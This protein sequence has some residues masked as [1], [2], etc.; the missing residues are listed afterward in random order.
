M[1][2]GSCSSDMT[3][4][5]L[6][7]FIAIAAPAVSPAPA[8]RSRPA[9]PR[10]D[11]SDF[12]PR[13]NGPAGS[14]SIR[15]RSRSRQPTSMGPLL[16]RQF[17]DQPGLA[18]PADDPDFLVKLP[19]CIG[20]TQRGAPPVCGMGVADD[21]AAIDQARQQARNLRLVDGAAA[22][23]VAQR[24]RAEFAQHR[25]GSPLGEAEPV[26]RLQFV[27][28]LAAQQRRQLVQA[29]GVELADENRPAA[30][31]PGFA[32]NGARLPGCG[33]FPFVLRRLGARFCPIR[34]VTAPAVRF[35]LDTNS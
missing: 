28:H 27:V 12:F 23:N 29:I 20:Q 25:N 16:A 26:P 19:A 8:G 17:F 4:T 33:G 15:A 6:C 11:H 32:H 22:R 9:S 14:V 34:H 31:R 13:A 21:V 5:R 35:Q 2:R 10:L 24:Q 18:L 1:K 3:M 30:G 7:G